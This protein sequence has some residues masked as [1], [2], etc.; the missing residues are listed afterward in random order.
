MREPRRAYRDD[1]SAV[2]RGRECGDVALNQ[3]CITQEVDGL[4]LH[5][6]RAR[7]GLK[8]RPLPDPRGT[9]L[10]K[11]GDALDAERERL[12]ELKPFSCQIVIK[13]NESR[14][15]AARPSHAFHIAVAYRIDA[16]REYD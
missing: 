8:D 2:G 7:R 14:G 16:L 4:D 12:G 9:C 3:G 13:L 5:A 11:H 1:Q 15:I 6:E 10:A